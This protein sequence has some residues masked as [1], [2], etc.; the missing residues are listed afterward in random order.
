MPPHFGVDFHLTSTC[1]DY[2]D[3]QSWQQTPGSSLASSSG[4]QLAP[5]L[6]FAG[7]LSQSIIKESQDEDAPSLNSTAEEPDDDELAL[8]GPP[9]AKEGVLARKH[10][11]EAPQKRAKDKAWT[12]VFV[13]VQKGMLS[14]FRFGETSS[15]AKGNAAASGAM[16]GGNWLVSETSA[17]PLHGTGLM[18][19][20]LVCLL[21]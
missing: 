21:L 16:G 13:V 8:M 14:M 20:F 19:L 7:T 12:E 4:S 17:L 11:W 3:T 15:A 18:K 5:S 1:L 2:C 9:W 10:Y 6:G